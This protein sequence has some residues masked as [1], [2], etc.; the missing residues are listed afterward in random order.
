MA[1]FRVYW[2]NGLFH[3][4]NLQSDISEPCD[5]T[6]FLAVTGFSPCAMLGCYTPLFQIMRRLIFMDCSVK[7]PNKDLV[8][9]SKFPNLAPKCPHALLAPRTGL[10]VSFN[11]GVARR[12]V[13][14]SRQWSPQLREKIWTPRTPKNNAQPSSDIKSKLLNTWM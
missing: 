12:D 9:S 14:T 8:N 11:L 7:S 1:K 4:V 2:E 6:C 3:I 13:C 5:S 10:G